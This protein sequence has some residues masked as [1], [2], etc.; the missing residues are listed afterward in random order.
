[1]DTTAPGHDLQASQGTWWYQYPDGTWVWW[2]TDES[3]WVR[4]E[5]PQ[6]APTPR[7]VWLLIA[8]AIVVT[9]VGGVAAVREFPDYLEQELERIE[10]RDRFETQVLEG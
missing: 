2:S 4:L 10:Q 1:M 3:R 5:V 7:W 6:T 9:I 8:I